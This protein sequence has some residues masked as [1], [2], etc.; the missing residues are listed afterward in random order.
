[1][2]RASS[3]GRTTAIANGAAG[4]TAVTRRWVPP[5]HRDERRYHHLDRG[6]Y[7]Y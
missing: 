4:R 2:R 5:G 1:M 7:R 3:S 6:D